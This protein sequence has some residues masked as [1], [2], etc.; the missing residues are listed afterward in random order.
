[1][2]APANTCPHC[3][4]AFPTQAQLQE[5]INSVHKPVPGR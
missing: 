2:T 4:A 5:H 1:M 3:A